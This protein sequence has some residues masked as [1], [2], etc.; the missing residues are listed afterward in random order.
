MGGPAER[1]LEREAVLTELAALARGVRRGAGRVA[2]LRGEAGIGK[3]AVITGFTAGL[4]RTVSVL[5]GGCDPLAAP[6]PLGPLLD[7]LTG[8]GPAAA[9]ALGDAIDA[10]DTAAL[11]R[12]LLAVLRD[13]RRWVWIIED[14]HWADGATLDLLRFLARRIGSLPLLLVVSYR[15]DELD[16]HHPLAVA[17]GDVATCAA[18]TRIGLD[19]LSNAAVAALAAGS[20]LNADRLHALT[21]GN[22]FFVTEVLAAGADAMGRNTLPRSVAEAV[23]GR[24]ARLST[25]AR[26]T[27]Q[28][29]AICGPRADAALVRRL[30]PAAGAGLTEC[31]NAGMLLAEGESV[32]FRHELARRA[33]LDRI[34]DYQRK[35]LHSRA[36]RALTEPPIDPNTLASLAFHAEEAGDHDAAMHYGLGAAQRA[37][38]LGAHRE[39]ADLYALVLRHAGNAPAEQRVAWIEQHARASYLG[40]HVQACVRSYRDAIALRHRLDDPLGEGDDLHRL[41]HVLSRLSQARKAGQAS[42]RLLEQCGPTPQLAASLAHLAELSMLAYDPAC[43]EYASRA[44]ALGTQLGL[45]AIVLKANYYAALNGLVH[46]GVGFD[47]V[48]AV[49]REAMGGPEFA[50]LAGLMGMGLCWQS[51]QL[52]ELD[53]AEGYIA[54]TTAFCAAHDLATFEPLALSAATLVALHRGDWARAAAY[55]EDVLSRPAMTPLH[56]FLP[57]TTLGLI[58]ARCGR[59]PALPLLDEALTTAEPDDFFRLGPLWPARAEAAWL[60]GDDDGARAEARDGLAS[61]PEHAHPL[62][63]GSLHRWL[64]LAGGEPDGHEKLSAP[65]QLEACGDWQGAAAEWTR[66][67]CPYEAAIAQ[68]GGDIPAVEAALATFRGLGATAAARRARQRLTQLRGPTRRTRR[69]DLHADPDGLS[70]REREV[71]TLIAAG[72]SDADI[73]TKLSL[74]RKTVGHHVESILTKLGADNRTQAAAHARERQI[75]ASRG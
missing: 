24:L 20:G 12:R 8:L 58:H 62:L 59:R 31:L 17:L 46:T 67:G 44:S 35:A 14:A 4:E 9:G 11:Y 56:R 73:A 54:E 64:R 42:L 34:D 53:R 2:L 63:V 41:S 10:G 51:A 30:C 25:G 36:L 6:R 65:F 45:P 75:T 55:A 32:R 66:R 16:A 22:P 71:L 40:G 33:T 50:E 38:G 49:W 5:W 13:G 69:T 23:W 29:V 18:V 60:R 27:A 74:S 61:A 28:A 26:A 43:S 37:A 72:H 39:A 15:D 1:L 68:L 3:T 21:G 19:P 47:E 70:R 48:E 57:L 7:A 52:Y